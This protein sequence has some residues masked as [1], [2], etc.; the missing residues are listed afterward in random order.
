MISKSLKQISLVILAFCPTKAV[1]AQ[2]FIKDYRHF[3]VEVANHPTQKRIRLIDTSIKRLSLTIS[4]FE[5]ENK[6]SFFNTDTIVMI[7]FYG[8]ESGSSSEIIWNRN[9]SCYYEYTYE[10]E[11]WKVVNQKFIVKTN[12]SDF[13]KS[14]DPEFRLLVE[15]E[16]T[17]DYRKYAFKHRVLD[18][19][20]VSPVL[21]VKSGRQW[22]FIPFEGMAMDCYNSFAKK[23]DTNHLS[24]I[25]NNLSKQ[26]FG[27]DIDSANVA[28]GS[29]SSKYKKQPSYPIILLNNKLINYSQLETIPV[30]RIKAISIWSK[31]S[32]N[33]A[34]PNGI[35]TESGIIALTTD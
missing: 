19:E 14:F 23:D 7:D 33:T 10:K 17:T 32:H 11:H 4:R 8:I 20:W 15:S 26:H 13:V 2:N 22:K 28:F 27:F 31:N 6:H 9:A 34:I 25:I 35:S 18:G 3:L 12:A 5:K 24:T 16:D 1:F 30:Y 29:D 21:A